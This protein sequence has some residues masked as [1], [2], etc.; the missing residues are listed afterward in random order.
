MSIV[1]SLLQKIRT[2][3]LE[4]QDAAAVQPKELVEALKVVFSETMNEGEAEKSFALLEKVIS[5]I[6]LQ[7]LEE[8]LEVKNLLNETKNHFETA[9]I[10]FGT[11]EVTPLSFYIHSVLNA[12]IAVV[13]SLI[14]AFGFG[15]FFE[16][17]ENQEQNERKSYKLMQLSHSFSMFS[18]L[19]IPVFGEERGLKIFAGFFASIAVLSLVWSKMK[20]MPTFLP[21]NAKNLSKEVLAGRFFHQVSVGLLED[22]EKV[23]DS[24][25]HP[26]L[27]GSSRVGKSLTAK[28]YA[29][30]ATKKGRSV[31]GINT[32]NL[33]NRVAASST[34]GGNNILEEISKAMGQYRKK[35]VLV[36]DEIHMACF[37]NQP[38]A[39]Q[40][41][42]FL[43][44]G[45]DFPMVIGITTEK[46]FEDYVEK[47]EA[48]RNRFKRINI[49]STDKDETLRVLSATALRNPSKPILEDQVLDYIYENT[50][51][52]GVPQPYTAD[53]LL[54]ECI[55]LT[56]ETQKSVTEKEVRA[57]SA[58]ILSIR[59][60]DAAYGI[61]TAN[62]EQL[63]DQLKTLETTFKSEQVELAKLFKAKEAY[64]RARKMVY[65]SV[66]KVAEIG[67]AHL[68]QKDE[69]ALKRLLV[70]DRFLKPVFVDYIK[71]KSVGVKSII[72][73]ALVDSV[74]RKDIK[75]M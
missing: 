48:F 33:I 30:Y 44:E 28:A 45:G 6:P 27:V 46:E 36:L 66:I 51:G 12:V 23:F 32:S 34:G 49:L 70:S 73:K 58:K 40:M 52:E 14:N 42:S 43:D 75:V 67:K 62:L 7:K 61:S 74:L 69:E 65:E 20:P 9:K 35:I 15:D 54:K 64:N 25:K 38:L 4:S 39:D 57:L 60:Q 16:P 18:A 53:N 11:K 19:M 24:G 37:P 56:R 50:N 63:E 3:T 2:H 17:S 68:T 29:E 1:T 41:K 10:Y 71:T 26:I 21:A 8:A 55:S 59:S 5:V 13:E 22:I 31:F 72:D 47:N